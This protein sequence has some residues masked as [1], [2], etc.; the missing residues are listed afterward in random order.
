[1]SYIPKDIIEGLDTFLISHSEFLELCGGKF[2]GHHPDVWVDYFYLRQ[3]RYKTKVNKKI[4]HRWISFF[5]YLITIGKPCFI[6]YESLDSVPE[7][8]N[9][10][11]VNNRS[12]GKFY[13]L[14]EA[15]DYI[16]NDELHKNKL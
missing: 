11:T 7:W 12:I 16:T 6:A 10:S 1:M 14:T 3:W 5:P 8:R 2:E 15:I 4:Q 9:P 13:T